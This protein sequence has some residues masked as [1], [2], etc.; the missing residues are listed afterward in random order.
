VK[1]R[2]NDGPT[3]PAAAY[4]KWSQ[5]E[6]PAT[7]LDALIRAAIEQ[8]RLV[9]LVYGDK[10]RILE[11]HDYGIHKGTVKLLGYQVGGSSSGRL[12]NW[13]W[14]E[15]KSISDLRLLDQ[16]FPGGRPSLSGKHHQW[17]QLFLRVKPV[18]GQDETASRGK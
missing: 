9:E 1:L 8:K 3:A 12:P 2:G 15:V 14:L 17:D 16:T 11:P 18:E 4:I 5:M 13:R 10:R 6:S 7:D